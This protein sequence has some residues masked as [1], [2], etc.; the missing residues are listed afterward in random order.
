MFG[1]LEE[2][3]IRMRARD[4]IRNVTRVIACSRT[5][6]N[7][8]KTKVWKRTRAVPFPGNCNQVSQLCVSSVSANSRSSVDV[9]SRLF[10][11]FEVNSTF[12][13][14]LYRVYLGHSPWTKSITRYSVRSTVHTAARNFSLRYCVV[15]LE[16]WQDWA[17]HN[18]DELS[19]TAVCSNRKYSTVGINCVNKWAKLLPSVWDVSASSLAWKQKLPV[20]ELSKGELSFWGFYCSAVFITKCQCCVEVNR[21]QHINWEPTETFAL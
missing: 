3:S 18:D 17:L 8:W 20:T 2:T 7:T 19:H 6:V 13:S 1:N 5:Y 9:A 4:T 10:C 15:K 12:A 11:L 14:V 21:W 16:C